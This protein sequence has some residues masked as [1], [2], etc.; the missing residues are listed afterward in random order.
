VFADEA[1]AD[2]LLWA[3]PSLRGRVVY[4]AAFELLTPAQLEAVADLKTVTGLDWL[5]PARGERVL[6]LADTG[7]PNPVRALR[8]AGRARLLYDRDG[9]AVLER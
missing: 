4:D 8:V 7:D 1:Y 2:W 3:L 6:V 9:A 5:R